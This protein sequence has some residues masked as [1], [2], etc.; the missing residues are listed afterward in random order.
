MDDLSKYLNA[1]YR[2]SKSIYYKYMIDMMV[3]NG[4]I[5]EIKEFMN[6]V[7]CSEKTY[8][9]CRNEVKKSLYSIGYNLNEDGTVIRIW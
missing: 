3:K 7:G 6:I 1:L 8:Y 5:P 4:K 2:M 9:N